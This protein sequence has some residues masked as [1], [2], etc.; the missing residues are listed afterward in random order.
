M[1]NKRNKAGLPL[2]PDEEALL[3]EMHRQTFTPDGQFAAH[4]QILRDLTDSFNAATGRSELASDL[5]HFIVVRRKTG[6][7]ITFGDDAINRPFRCLAHLSPETWADI[8]SLYYRMRIPT[9]RLLF[10]DEL[11]LH[12]S[13]LVLAKTGRSVDV[14]TLRA[15]LIQRR[16]DGLLRPLGRWPDPDG[17]AMPA[18]AG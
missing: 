2:F 16:K 1:E 10:D 7:W 15:G 14:A 3:R 12:F 13:Q 17:N 18:M 6:R 5:L 9:D 4:P 8:D 11:A